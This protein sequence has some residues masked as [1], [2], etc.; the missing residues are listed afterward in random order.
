[1]ASDCSA[2]A[3]KLKSFEHELKALAEAEEAVLDALMLLQEKITKGDR[4]P[5]I[6]PPRLVPERAQAAAHVDPP[7]LAQTDQEAKS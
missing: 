4:E 3:V 1:M 2:L 5:V 6:V 7:E